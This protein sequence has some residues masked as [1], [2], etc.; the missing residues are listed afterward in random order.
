MLAHQQATVSHSW[1]GDAL[2]LASPDTGLETPF[3]NTAGGGI[4]V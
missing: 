4:Q 3:G 2:N 1:E